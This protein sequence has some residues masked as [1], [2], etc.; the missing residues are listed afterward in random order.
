MALRL[1]F[2]VDIG[3][4]FKVRGQGRELG[5]GSVSGSGSGLVYGRENS[6]FLGWDVEGAATSGFL[7]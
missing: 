4:R 6:G 1:S 3:F 2:W 5:E 7:G